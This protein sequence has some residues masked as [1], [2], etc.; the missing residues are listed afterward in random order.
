[1]PE[2]LSYKFQ[3]E[4]PPPEKSTPNANAEKPLD[5]TGEKEK[6]GSDVDVENQKV[7]SSPKLQKRGRGRRVGNKKGENEVR[8]SPRFRKSLKC[9]KSENGIDVKESEKGKESKEV[10]EE[11]ECVENGVSDGLKKNDSSSSSSSSK[12]SR[13][14]QKTEPNV[15]VT[16]KN[17]DPRLR[18]NSVYCKSE[19]I[20]LSENKEPEI[21]VVD[22]ARD[23]KSDIKT[24]S[25]VPFTN[26]SI[27]IKTES[28]NDRTCDDK[29]EESTES[30]LEKL[31]GFGSFKK[32]KK[33]ENEG[34][35]KGGGGEEEEEGGG[36]EGGAGGG[37][38]GGVR[39]GG[40]GEEGKL[41]SVKTEGGGPTDVKIVQNGFE[42]V[43]VENKMRFTTDDDNNVN[44]NF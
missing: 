3:D 4:K 28:L 44:F 1:M 21:D 12:D 6:E 40:G 42:N 35:V 20:P 2:N 10:R 15:S 9:R 27:V 16:V 34:G 8:T 24:E 22:N 13:S 31:D 5:L 18:N 19:K 14:S 7:E 11:E 30:I 38:G 43:K 37:S 25:T 26:N 29:E 32:E 17:L 33:D 23:S 41:E 39:E 36:D